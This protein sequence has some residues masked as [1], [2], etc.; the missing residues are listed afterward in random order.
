MRSAG[1]ASRTA[2]SGG[3]AITGTATNA[4][5]GLANAHHVVP[6]LP[7]RVKSKRRRKSK[8]FSLFL[9]SLPV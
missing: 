7:V 2:S 8:V 5:I 6:I 9:A 4:I 3:V 1:D